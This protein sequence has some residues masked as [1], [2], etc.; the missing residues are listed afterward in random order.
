MR[1]SGVILVRALTAVAVAVLV[2]FGAFVASGCG[3]GG[4][5][6]AESADEGV[7]VE[8]ALREAAHEGAEKRAVFQAPGE[9]AGSGEAD[10]E[11]PRSP[12][13]EAVLDR[14]YPRS[15]VDDRLA[16]QTLRTFERV[17]S[18]P[19]PAAFDSAAAL[20]RAK[21]TTNWK[22][23]GPRTP[24]V[25]GVAS[26]FFDP[27]T[28]KGPATQE[29]GRVTALAIDPACAPG[30]CRMAVAAAGGGIWTTADALASKVS[31]QAPPGDLP[32]TSFGSLY[33]D[34]PRGILFAGSGEPNGSSDSEAGLG[35]FKSADFGGSWTKVPGSA[36]VAT[37][38]SIGAIAVDPTDPKTIYIGTALARHG[39]SAVWGGRRTPPDAPALGVYRSTDGGQTF[40]LEQDLANKALPSPTNPRSGSDYFQG[41]ITKLLV[42]P[43]DPSQLYAGVFGYGIWRAN[44][45]AASPTWTQVFHTMN[46]NDFS[47]GQFVGDYTGDKTDFDLV[48][49]GAK[50]R[51]YVGD[52]SDDWAIDG[53]DSTPLPR[54]WRNDDAAA[55]VGDPNGKLPANDPMGDTFNE[56][57]GFKE[58]SSDEPSDP[59]FAVYDY[60]QNG[61]CGYDSLVAH[62]PGA[63]PSQVWYLGSM[64]YDELKAYDRYGQGAPPRSNGR[65]V[66]RSTNA[67]G[68]ISSITWQ[69]MTAVLGNAKADWDVIQGIHPD[70]HA[71]AFAENGN[72]AFIGSDGGVVRIDASKP[73][74]QSA[75][76][77]KRTWDYSGNGTE[78]PLH[79]NDAVLCRMLLSGVP[80]S[81]LPLN[82]GLRTLQFQSLSVNPQGPQDQLL[83]GTQDNGTW[84]YDSARQFSNRWFESVGGDGGQSGFDRSSSDIR[85]HNY[86]DATPE[87]NFSGDDPNAWIDIYDPLQLS[88]EDRSFYTPFVADPTTA[89]R[90]FTG[91]QH[92]WR[93]DDNGG[94]EQALKDNGCLSLTLDPFRTQPCGDWQPMGADLT[95]TAFG[96]DRAGQ[97]VAALARAPSND[98]TLWAA[99]RTGR[100]FVTKNADAVPGAVSFN[101]IDRPTTPGRFVSGIAV[102]PTNPNRAYVSYSGYNAYT[103]QTPGHVFE[104]TYRPNKKKAHFEDI[105]HN[106]GDQPITGLALYGNDGSLFAAT[107]FGVLELPAGSKQWVEAGKGLPK[108]ATYGL[109]VSD[110]GRV[111][112]AAT[113]GRGAFSLKLPKTKPTA[114]LKKIH[115]VKRGKRAK[116]RGRA[117]DPGAVTKATIRFGDGKKARVKLRK[118]GRFKLRHRY[119]KA[120]THRVTLSVTG[121]EGKTKKATRKV[122]VKRR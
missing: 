119:R 29:S 111:L 51:M 58:M 103:P 46:Q 109:T 24:H 35:L 100:L 42:D 95:G 60:C 101:R 122:K 90:L 77:A 4:K 64:N 17:P 97:F 110:S 80:T 106:L 49:L 26:Q 96:D 72:V 66:I 116:I 114:K 69:D 40:E 44:Q 34:A 113:H 121:Y 48:D 30:D 89:G 118:D 43:N 71:A 14:A 19:S 59:G 105:S 93:T 67:G 54:A 22:E 63:P 33:Y 85:F 16:R 3:G 76:C 91:M 38:R 73:R 65:A 117:T 7:P 78:E 82:R 12:A 20:R 1:N 31:W 112:W 15:Y 55:I 10:R 62:P 23:V 21:A 36:A 70:L 9:E 79:H 57:N 11:G 37:N 88:D 53:D 41:G 98:G 50:T 25:P 52:A 27:D 75:S 108:V 32:T 18:E 115:P 102:D 5:D 99:T 86:Y 56:N 87:V 94:D 107:D 28:L 45:S 83:G 81:V 6:G 68:A 47:G 104:V 92:V 8:N 84:S 61:Q 120:G 74:N 39:M 2:I 13:S